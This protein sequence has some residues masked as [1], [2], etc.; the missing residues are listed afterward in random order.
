MEYQLMLNQ[1]IAIPTAIVSII[2]GVLG[3]RIGEKQK[4]NKDKQSRNNRG[5]WE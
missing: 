2:S 3:W 5:T 4:K 1:L